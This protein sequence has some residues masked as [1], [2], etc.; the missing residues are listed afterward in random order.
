MKNTVLRIK[1]E[2]ENVKKIY[3]DDDFVWAFN[4]RDSV[5]TLTRENITFSKNDQLAI[6]NSRGTANFLVK[7]TEYPKYST[8]NFVNTKKSC[9]YDSASNEWQD[10]AT[11]ECRGIELAEFIPSGDFIIEDTQGKIYYNVNLFD[12]NWCDYNQD[13]E[14]CVGVYNLEHEIV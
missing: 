12:L 6:P 1:A 8:I 7:W 10:F 11:F 2:L 3:C 13:H 14:M 9:S 5:S 4:I